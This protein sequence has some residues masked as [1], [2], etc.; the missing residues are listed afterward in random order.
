MFPNNNRKEMEGPDGNRMITNKN[1]G[2]RTKESKIKESLEIS[3]WLI[4][5]SPRGKGNRYPP[6]SLFFFS[7]QAKIFAWNHH[8]LL[9]TIAGEIQTFLVRVFTPALHESWEDAGVHSTLRPHW[10]CCFFV[11][12][13]PLLLPACRKKNLF[14]DL[15]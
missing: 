5:G 12:S 2:S 6:G 14:L 3:K 7:L 11:G 13:P 4:E 8:K 1:V 10:V 9:I 15:W